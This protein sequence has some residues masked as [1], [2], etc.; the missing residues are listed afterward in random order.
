MLETK[1]MTIKPI[2]EGYHTVTPYMIIKD[3]AAAL[4]FYK[5]AFSAEEIGQLV[6]PD[7]TIMHG[8]FKIGNS[9]VMYAE[10]NLDMSMQGPNVLGGAAISIC[11][12]VE[13]ADD[14]FEQAIQAGAK[15]IRPIEDQFWGDRSGTVKDPF[16]HSWTILTQIEKVS[17]DEM[18]QRF[19]KMY[20]NP[21]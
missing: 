20:V 11:L 19:E 10:E 3:A 21:E 17:W 12:Y 1:L 5:Q 16:G 13:N 6:T 18:Q 7:G 15:E 2:P 9:H 14:V 4:A 8:E